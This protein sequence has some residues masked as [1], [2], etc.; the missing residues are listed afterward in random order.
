MKAYT[1]M[2]QEELLQEKTALENE[3]KKI[4]ELGLDLNL[5]RGKPS[6]AQLDLSMDMY[7]M[8]HS[9]IELV[10]EDGTDCRNYGGMEG[11][12][13]A[14]R[15]LAGFMGCWPQDVIVYGNASLS[16]M[17]DSISRSMTHG[18]LGSTPWCKLDRV[19]F[20][21]PVPGYDR[22]F[23]ITEHFG[24]EMINIPMTPEGPDMDLVEKLVSE[25][26][27]VKGIWCVPKYSNPQ[28]ITYSDETVR[29]F[30]ALKP[31]AEDFRIYW[32]NAYA[33]HD[34]YEDERDELLPIM[35]EC[36][37]AGNPDIVYQFCST[38]KVTFSGAGMSAMAASEAN[39]ES[40]RK[41]MSVQ[42]IGHDKIK[43]WVHCRYLKDMDGV[44]AHMK[45]HAALV[46]P[47]FEA[48]ETVL[49]QEIVSR[50]IG[51]WIKPKGGYFICFESMEGCA[52]A[53]IAKAK[54]AGITLT[55]A[56]APFPY[57]KDPKDSTIRIAPTFPDIEEMKQAAQ[58][59]AVCIRLVSAE[60]LLLA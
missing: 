25:D 3:Y 50:G 16:I 17:Y 35:N 27:A 14:K 56:G 22:H 11:I 39:R 6:P 43:Q 10:A 40:I 8:L 58:A 24:I 4:K 20:L 57:K 1:S 29:R 60:K 59:L 2:T 41:Q 48:V 46:R 44:R 5:T 13:E 42:T 36:V 7:D 30:A 28:G 45:K 15:L 34:L 18:V 32:D 52:K 12:G 53:I 9:G 21:C 47:K 38:S 49:E 26:D 51:S 55:A 23:S 19:K 31:A 37:K 33:V 54:E